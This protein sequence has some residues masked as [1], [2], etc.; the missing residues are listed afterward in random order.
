MYVYRTDYE[1]KRVSGFL[2]QLLYEFQKCK[3]VKNKSMGNKFVL[4][5]VRKCSDRTDLIKLGLSLKV[6]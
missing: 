3:Q 4:K 2:D 5:T 1:N 6:N